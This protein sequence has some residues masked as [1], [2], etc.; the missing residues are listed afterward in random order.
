MII[1]VPI[2]QAPN[3]MSLSGHGYPNVGVETTDNYYQQYFELFHQSGAVFGGYCGASCRSWN[4]NDLFDN[5]SISS[6]EDSN[7][8]FHLSIVQNIQSE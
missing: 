2:R 3:E 1:T 7:F 5:E 6:I 8:M 4:R